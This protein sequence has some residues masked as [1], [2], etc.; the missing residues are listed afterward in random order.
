MDELFA[1]LTGDL[2]GRLTGPLTFRLLMQPAVA[3]LLAVRDG[4]ADARSHRPAYLWAVLTNAGYRREALTTGWASIAKVF[5]LAFLLD[6]VYQAIA[7]RWF[8]P[9]E[10][11]IVAVLLA[12]VP[13]VALRGPVSRLFRRPRPSPTGAVES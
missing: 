11:L 4:L 1:R 13:Y 12:I 2:A 3:V 9:G 7:L 10:A 5:T 6:G 8:Y